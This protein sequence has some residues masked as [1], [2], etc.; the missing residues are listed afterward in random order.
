[1]ARC[2]QPRIKIGDWVRLNKNVTRKRN[3]HSNGKARVARFYNDIEGGVRLQT[4]LDG[5]RSWNVSDL[6]RLSRPKNTRL[7]SAGTLDTPEC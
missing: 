2:K 5:F 3:S 7:T 4:P 6:V 1:M